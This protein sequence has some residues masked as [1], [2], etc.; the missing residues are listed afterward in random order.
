MAIS[1]ER[2]NELVEQYVDLLGR[3]NGFVIVQ[4][5]GLSVKET[6]TLRAQIREAGGAYHVTK[7]TLFTK[8]LQQV[9]WPV[10]DDLLTGPVAVAFGM[11]NLPGVA[12]AILDFTDDKTRQGDLRATGG[13]MTGE[14]L[15]ANKIKAVSKLP[16]L[17]EIRAQLA[18]LIVAPAP[19][20]V[21]VINAA[22]GQ[23]VN[24]ILA[25]LDENKRDDGE[26]A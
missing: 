26:A 19:G 6:D 8:A 18:G 2:K 20:F 9:G 7:N 11:E 23:V 13:I 25:Y 10:P 17:D 16:S 12:K 21:S 1:K 24:V 4:Y 22:N 14:I 15:D 5:H 3:T